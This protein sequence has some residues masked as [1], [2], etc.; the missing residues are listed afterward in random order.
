MSISLLMDIG[1]SA[2]NAQ[3]L[4]LDVAGE[5]IANVNTP[6]YSRQTA[7]LQSQV[8]V[9][10]NGLPTG[11]GVQVVAVQRAYDS[12][13]QNQLVQANAVSGGTTTTNSGMQMIQPLFN[14]LAA[15][16]T[17]GLSAPI[18]NF[19]SAW[20]DLASNPQGVAERQAVISQGQQLADAFHTMSAG[21]T[22]VQGNMNQNLQE[23]T[24]N[25]N[26]Q[27][28][29]V[30]ALN[31]QIQAARAQGTQANEL[32]DQRNYLVQ[33][34]S[35]NVGVT[36]T[37]QSDGSMTVTLASGYGGSVLVSGKTAGSLTLQSNASNSGFYDVIANTVGQGPVNVTSQ[38][39][40]SD[41]QGVLGATLQMRD[42]TINGYLSGLNELASTLVQ[43]V[44]AAQ[45]GGYGLD[46]STGQNFF[47]PTTT[48]ADMSVAVTSTDQIAAANADPTVGGTGNNINAQ[49]VA[50]L[51]NTNFAMTG[52]NMTLGGFYTSLMGQ[53]GVGVQSATQND[54]Q[55]TST[56]NQLNNLWTST[57]GVSLDEELTNL[58]SQQRAYQ[59]AAKMVTVG[60]QML[61]TILGMVQ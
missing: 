39:A 51:A 18:Q 54:N 38:L 2:L 53:V 4:A 21:L 47:N 16:G 45:S 48:A 23:I 13:L 7:V 11:S 24:S 44:N 19:F 56:I 61:D 36:A 26:N 50:A 10:V 60:T 34:L 33:Q 6:G 31:V 46:G 52:G 59:G 41:Y 8:P 40:Q 35:N 20:Q 12:F 22:S 43:Q 58:T 15:S 27:L 17:G 25:V 14:D 1:N 57:S 3:R 5:N 37:E 9:V 49:A 55:A 30:A 28:K 42:T 32:E 29:Q